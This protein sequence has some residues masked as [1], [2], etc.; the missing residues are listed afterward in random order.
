[1]LTFTV[2]DLIVP[3]PQTA[4][5]VTVAP[6]PA[7]WLDALVEF[8]LALRYPDGHPE[9][10]SFESW[11]ANNRCRLVHRDGRTLATDDREESHTG[12]S[13]AAA[14]R[15]RAAD[16]GDLAGWSL[17]LDTPGPLREFPVRFTLRDVPLP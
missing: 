7:R 9:F 5:G 1:M 10:E 17:V 2:P 13:V 4:E 12:R 6:Q 15:F 8:R 14:Y 11:T 3:K 16:V